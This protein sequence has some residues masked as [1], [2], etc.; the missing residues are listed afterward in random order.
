MKN[1]YVNRIVSN[2]DTGNLAV[3]LVASL[4]V[5]AKENRSD[6]ILSMKSALRRDGMSSLEIQTVM[7][8][9]LIY[10]GIWK[11]ERIVEE[12]GE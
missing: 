5:R 6:V 12:M 4:L 7:C 2:P 9:A 3:Q 10:A 1:E 11:A 8:R